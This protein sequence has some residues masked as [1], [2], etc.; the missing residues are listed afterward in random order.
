VCGGLIKCQK[1][2][3]LKFIRL[4]VVLLL[5]RGAAMINWRRRAALRA[6]ERER[7]ND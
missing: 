1:C 7:E 5:V 3:S 6:D 4:A 2:A